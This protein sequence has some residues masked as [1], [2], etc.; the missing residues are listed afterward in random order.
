MERLVHLRNA[1]DFELFQPGPPDASVYQRLGISPDRPLLLTVTRLAYEKKLHRVLDAMP[2]LLRSVPGAVAVMVGEGP[3]RGALEARARAL[4]IQASVR[5][6]GA[7]ANGDLPGW[8]RSASAVLSLLD[9]TNASNPVFEAMACGRCVVALDVGTTRE[10]VVPER[11]GVLIASHDLPH[12]GKIL[13]DLLLS[14]RQRRRMSALCS[15]IP[16]I[17]WIWRLRSSS[18][19]S[20]R[21]ARVLVRLLGFPLRAWE[22]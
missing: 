15:S 20:R 19:R 10:V 22:G 6:P 4:G 9:R 12:L 21:A 1:L 7:V 18:K 11:T 14:G 17:A 16:Q 13:A 8:Y 3:R 2:E 5:I